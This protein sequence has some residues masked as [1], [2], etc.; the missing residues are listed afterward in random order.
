MDTENITVYESVEDPSVGYDESTIGE[1]A[2][3]GADFDTDAG[4][5][6]DTGAEGTGE[7]AD[8]GVDDTPFKSFATE[9]EYREEIDRIAN[10]RINSEDNEYFKRSG[11]F[12]GVLEKLKAMYNVESDEEALSLID[13]QYYDSIAESRGITRESAREMA[14]LEQKAAA[15]DQYRQSQ[16]EYRRNEERLSNIRTQVNDFKQKNPDFDMNLE[17]QNEQFKNYIINHNMTVEDAYYLVHRAEM[18][19]KA[20]ESVV[21]N[22]NAKAARITENGAGNVRPMQA[23]INPSNLKDSDIDDILRRVANGERIEF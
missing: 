21:S 16:E 17:I 6:S 4:T 15:Y 19:Q 11:Q 22:I 1:S 14:E 20:M 5:T 23:R 2:Y 10:E 13:D 8:A 7:N 9:D 3:N 12:G 18:E